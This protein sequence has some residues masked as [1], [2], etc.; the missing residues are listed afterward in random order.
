LAIRIVIVLKVLYTQWNQTPECL[1]AQ[2]IQ[3]AH[4][5][6]RERFSALY[7]GALGR[8]PVAQQFPPNHKTPQLSSLAD[9][10]KIFLSHDLQ[11]I[12]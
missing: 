9:P 8:S 3:V 4:P 10:C 5:R 7:Q 1:L 6:T 11:T 12:L 2:S